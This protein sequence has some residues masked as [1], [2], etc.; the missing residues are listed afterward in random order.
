MENKRVNEAYWIW[1][2]ISKKEKKI[3]NKIK[4]EIDSYLDGPKF[5]LHLTLSGPIKE[6]NQQNLIK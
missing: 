3:L 2:L 1:L 4:K 6:I 5:E